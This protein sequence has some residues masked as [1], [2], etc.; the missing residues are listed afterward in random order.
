[1]SNAALLI[2]GCGC[3]GAYEGRVFKLSQSDGSVVWSYDT[4][5]S[6]KAVAVDSSGNVYITGARDVTNNRTIWKLN[7]AG[8]LVWSYDTGV[9]GYGIVTDDTYI[10][11]V[12]ARGYDLSPPYTDRMS[13]WKI[14]PGAAT[15]LKWVY[16]TGDDTNDVALDGSGNVYVGGVESSSKSFWKLN[17]SGALQD[18]YLMDDEVTGIYTD[19][20]YVWLAGVGNTVD[21]LIKIK[22]GGSPELKWTSDGSDGNSDCKVVVDDGYVYTAADNY[23]YASIHKRDDSDGSW[24]SSFYYQSSP[25]KCAVNAN[26]L[27]VD[28]SSNL[29]FVANNCQDYPIA[30][31]D[32]N[33]LFKLSTD[34][35]TID[36][37]KV[38]TPATGTEKNYGI[39]CDSSYVYMVGDLF[40][41]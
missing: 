9:D 14:E 6:A 7:S 18:D 30:D 5:T 3:C 10:Y 36:W 22:P 24:D 26:D 39:T 41:V 34:M 38:M 29:Y 23:S 25:Q 17:S 8:V 27:C 2:P 15:E 1:M 19:G 16:D 31:I 40:T 33:V 37:Y 11:V 35:S 20:T 4:G 12:G 32:D 28:G 21:N 13:V